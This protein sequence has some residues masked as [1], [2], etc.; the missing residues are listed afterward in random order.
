M[1]EYD[2]AA[3]KHWRAGLGMPEIPPAL[4]IR[5]GCALPLPIVTPVADVLVRWET[6]Y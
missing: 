1:A 6:T 4:V 3:A 2:A 5:F